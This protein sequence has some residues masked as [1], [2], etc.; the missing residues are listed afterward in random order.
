ME[1]IDVVGDSIRHRASVGGRTTKG[2]E[3]FRAALCRARAA[4]PQKKNYYYEL[5][6]IL[7]KSIEIL[8]SHSFDNIAINF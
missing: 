1:M 7:Y 5:L 2:S 3:F 6:M 8:G 4:V